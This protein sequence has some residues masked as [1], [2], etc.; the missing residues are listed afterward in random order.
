[1][2]DQNTL[3]EI[4][5]EVAEIIRATAE[6]MSREEILGFFGHQD[7]DDHQKNLILEYLLKI[8]DEAIK[9]VKEETE[10]EKEESIDSKEEIAEAVREALDENDS[11]LFEEEEPELN[12]GDTEPAADESVAQFISDM[13]RYARTSD[14]KVTTADEEASDQK[15]TAESGAAAEWKEIEGKSMEAVSGLDEGFGEGADDDT[16]TEEDIH[17]GND[18]D[19]ENDT[20]QDIAQDTER[21][22]KYPS[23]PVFKM[24][25]EEIERLPEYSQE[26]FERLYEGLLAGDAQSIQQISDGWMRRVLEQTVK[27]EVS[28]EDFA[29]VIQEGNMALFITLSELCGSNKKVDVEEEL[30]RAT[31]TAMKSFIQGLDSENDI[32]N[33]MIGKATLVNEARKHLMEENQ[34]TPSLNEL[35]A[36]TNMSESELADVLD[37]IER[38]ERNEK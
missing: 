26:T 9:E 10:A 20:D 16:D 5:R 32:R 1:M 13:S 22:N 34:Q 35:A 15:E 3:T 29:D 37:W 12:F 23:S 14:K 11:D 24:Y 18:E 28:D 31:M 7:L 25:L 2:L 38:A 21:K 4:L 19:T 36:Y 8:Q 6:P 27:L 33:V 30:C 17:I